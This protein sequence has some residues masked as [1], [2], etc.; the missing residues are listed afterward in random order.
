MMSIDI[1]N[2]PFDLMAPSI[3]SDPVAKA[4]SWLY[5]AVLTQS[6]TRPAWGGIDSR[7]RQKPTYTGVD[8]SRMTGKHTAYNPIKASRG[9]C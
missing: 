1:Q 9:V 5:Q 3:Y 8:T 4:L 7:P 6:V 2:A